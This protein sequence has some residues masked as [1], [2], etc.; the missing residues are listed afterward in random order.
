LSTQLVYQQFVKNF[1]TRLSQLRPTDRVK[2]V[3]PTYEET[4][5]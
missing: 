2:V 3:H 5:L 4:T 1:N